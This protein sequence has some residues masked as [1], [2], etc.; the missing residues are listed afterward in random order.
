MMKQK[1]ITFRRLEG[2]QPPQETIAH[3][4]E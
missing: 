4:E 2:Y 3:V 1:G